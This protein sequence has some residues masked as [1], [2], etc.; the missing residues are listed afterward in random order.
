ML[1]K[2]GARHSFAYMQMRP[3]TAAQ[4]PPLL[5]APR[6]AAGAAFICLLSLGRQGEGSLSELP[7]KLTGTHNH[8][9]TPG[10]EEQSPNLQ[11]MGGIPA[12]AP[13]TVASTSPGFAGRKAALLLGLLHCPLPGLKNH[14][15]HS[16]S[17]ARPTLRLGAQGK[18][19]TR[20][21]PG[22]GRPDLG[23]SSAIGFPITSSK[24]QPRLSRL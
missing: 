16:F 22:V 13:T 4:K 12:E 24:P 1:E 18:E 20:Q 2:R 3:S 9:N 14:Q 15:A 19:E 7:S 17:S 8:P 10:L 21:C 11:S 23:P 6:S 5:R